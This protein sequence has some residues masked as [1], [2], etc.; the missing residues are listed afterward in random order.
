M[1]RAILNSTWK[2]QNSSCTATYIPSL[3]PSKSDEQDTRDTAW[4]VW[5]NSSGT[6]SCGPH[7]NDE[8]LLDEH[9]R[10]YL[11]QLCMDTGCSLVELS[12]SMDDRDDWRERVREMIMNIVNKTE[13]YW[14]SDTL[15]SWKKTKTDAIVDNNMTDVT[16]PVHLWKTVLFA[17]NKIKYF[18]EEIEM[19]TFICHSE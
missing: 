8:H 1:L 6:F 2:P 7:H 17:N 19:K 4:R 3:K 9:V 12:N 11:Q 5:T 18:I 15:K 10:T 14:L 16:V 13:R